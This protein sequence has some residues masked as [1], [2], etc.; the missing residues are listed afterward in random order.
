MNND[1]SIKP[2]ET[3]DE[4]SIYTKIE[5]SYHD[6]IVVECNFAAK[7]YFDDG[8]VTIAS[9]TVLDDEV[10]QYSDESFIAN[11]SMW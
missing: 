11:E 7:Q 8:R 2:L 5:M 3:Y 6:Q 9:T 10:F 1:I 4:R